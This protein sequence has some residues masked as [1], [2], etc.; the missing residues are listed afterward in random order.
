MAPHCLLVGVGK[1]QFM[2]KYDLTLVLVNSFTE[3]QT[4]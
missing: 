2:A 4:H 3:T 1:L